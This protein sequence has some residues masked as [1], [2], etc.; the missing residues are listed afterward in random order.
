LNL[1][2]ENVE[3]G[4]VLENFK[5]F[6]KDLP[7]DM[8]GLCL[9]NSLEIRQIHNEFGNL[10]GQLAFGEEGDS[11]NR[12]ESK[13]PFHFVAFVHKNG[14]IYELDGLKECPIVVCEDVTY[15]NEDEDWKGRVLEIIKGR[16]GD[17]KEIRFNLMALV[18]DRREKLK[19]EIVDL[20]RKI[21]G[22]DEFN[23]SERPAWLSKRFQTQQELDE[24]EG[25]WSRYRHDWAKIQ[26]EM[27]IQLQ[28][29]PKPKPKIPQVISSQVQDLL[30]SMTAKGLIPK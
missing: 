29:K 15:T 23:S 24:E 27:Q 4:S 25:K 13:D 11:E 21:E 30:N 22:V 19:T 18:E 1:N 8:R 2:K 14:K 9:S 16:V 12:K 7:A 6:A 26:G 5:I 17:D 20:T 3:L 10:E 28:S